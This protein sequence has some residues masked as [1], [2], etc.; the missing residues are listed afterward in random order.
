MFNL[1]QGWWQRI[2]GFTSRTIRQGAQLG[3]SQD[4]IL[5]WWHWGQSKWHPGDTWH[6]GRRVHRRSSLLVQCLN[7]LLF[8]K[9]EFFCNSIWIKEVILCIKFYSLSPGKLPNTV[10]YADEDTCSKFRWKLTSLM[11]W[12]QLFTTVYNSCSHWFC[13]GWELLR[14]TGPLFLSSRWRGADVA[15]YKQHGKQR[16]ASAQVLRAQWLGQWE[17]WRQNHFCYRRLVRR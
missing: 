6:G 16:G 11:P 5:F 14:S 1:F 15:T 3:W 10:A 12:P 17:M 4:S 2:N 7:C 13:Q 8:L 9:K